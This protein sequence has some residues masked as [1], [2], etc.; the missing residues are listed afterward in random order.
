[1]NGDLDLI[2]LGQSLTW[3]ERILR[4]EGFVSLQPAA[5]RPGPVP[6]NG[7]PCG[8]CRKWIPAGVTHRCEFGHGPQ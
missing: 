3:R 2:E 7:Y 8:F 6:Y 4:L 1:M 5:H